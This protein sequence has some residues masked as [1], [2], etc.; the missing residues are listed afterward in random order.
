MLRRL[1]NI[2]LVF[3]G[4][5]VLLVLSAVAVG[6]FYSDEVKGLMI[7]QLN[8]RLRTEVVVG[9]FDVSL[10]RHF[11]YASLE[12]SD[13]LIKEVSEREK[14]DTLLF[15]RRISLLFNVLSFYHKDYTVNRVI[16]AKGLVRLKV[17]KSGSRNYEFWKTD[18]A[19][20]GQ[21]FDLRRV[22]IRDMHVRYDDMHTGQE[23]DAL[24]HD[25]RFSGRFGEERYDM[26][27][28]GDL[29]VERLAVDGNEFIRAKEAHVETG[30]DIDAN[31]SLY[32]I[33]KSELRIADFKFSLEGRLIAR[34]ATEMDL[35]IS[36]G[37]NDL[38]ALVSLL[39]E[40]YAGHFRDF[41]SEGKFLFNARIKGTSSGRSV[42]DVT[43]DFS[44]RSG[45]M[46]PPNRKISLQDIELKGSYSSKMHGILH[47]PSLHARLG[48]QSVNGD[49]KLTDFNSPFL[50]LHAQTTVEL[51]NL[52]AF[53]ASDTLEDLSG[54][55]AIDISFAGQIKEIAEARNGDL[56]NI[57][58][59]GNVRLSNVAF[60]LKGNP[61]SF[62]AI[63]GNLQLVNTDVRV[64]ALQGTISSS[65]FRFDGMFRNLIPFFLSPYQPTA[66]TA[67][68]NA[69]MI[70]LDE[71]LTNKKAAVTGDT[72]YKLAVD[73][74]LT[75]D[76]AIHVGK[77]KLRD[78]R[79]N[80]LSGNVHLQEQVLY[81]QELRFKAMRGDVRMN[82]VID[83]SRHD[84]VRM[85]CNADLKKLDVRQL[86]HE[87]ENYGQDVLTDR[88]VFGTVTAGIS[89]RSTWTN[90]LVIDPAR[91]K[92]TCDITIENGELKGFKPIQ[93]LSKYIRLADLNDIRFATLHNVISIQDR[94][95]SIPSM[96]IH[97]SALDL[98]LNG[99]HDFDNNIDYHFRLS[100][101]ELLG[102]KYKQQQTSEFGEVEDDGLGHTQLFLS[103]T[104]TVDEPK[105]SYDTKAV[106]QK[107]KQDIRQEKETV[108][109]LLREEFKIFKK[110]SVKKTTAP[111]KKKEELEI[112]Y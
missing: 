55:A 3:V 45:R 6:Y 109:D 107:L 39:P 74:R 12:L 9:E 101:S 93:A 90:D 42:P 80:A 25:I 41:S 2:L 108:K 103:M 70:D 57:N 102:K 13:V 106:R 63:N 83:V 79:A 75:A 66:I 61:L 100:L 7:S 43:A 84:S 19:S 68:L 85:S 112:E 15:T 32:A 86:F 21:D 71:L 59:S 89:F 17:D 18:T 29:L 14:K 16:I 72:S 98:A 91:V 11:P 65:D 82:A 81:G 73:P 47:I 8:K 96:D 104:G 94:T 53:L 40:K 37:E 20:A 51:S 46:T 77:L 69:S 54:M 76:L 36:A 5:V 31:N 50:E 62:G 23:Y 110:D 58:S 44:I 60:R 4:L 28:L 87:L 10:L 38:A 97:S 88:H 56:Q 35:R 34:K 111:V 64:D 33:R 78:F 99:T 30:L 92:A 22:D 67:S 48:Q 26:Q 95:I 27:I 49:L 52:S 1:R 105:I 24:L